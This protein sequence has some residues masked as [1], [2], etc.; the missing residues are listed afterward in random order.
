MTLPTLS[1][2]QQSLLRPAAE[3][4]D[5]RQRCSAEML[6]RALECSLCDALAVIAELTRQ[7]RLRASENGNDFV[8]VITIEAWEAA[9]TSV[10]T[11]TAGGPMNALTVADSVEEEMAGLLNETAS[12]PAAKAA[13]PPVEPAAGDAQ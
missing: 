9:A 1:P 8:P 10:T 3:L 6:K 12:T 5:R 4:A 13:T 7:G 11:T 2:H